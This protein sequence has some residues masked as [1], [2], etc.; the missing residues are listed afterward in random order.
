M[1]APIIH[2]VTDEKTPRLEY[3][4]DFMFNQVLQ[5]PFRLHLSQSAEIPSENVIYYG[6]E[7]PSQKI[8]IKAHPLLFDKSND[9]VKFKTVNY[10]L[11]T[12]P[13]AVDKGGILP[14]DPFA[15]AFYF[16]SQYEEQTNKITLDEHQRFCVAD[17]QIAPYIHYPMVDTICK[18]LKLRLMG[19]GILFGKHE[20]RYSFLPTFDIDI[21]YAHQAKSLK[22][23]FLGT[24]KLGAKF[25]YKEFSERV[26]VWVGLKGDPYD[27]FD[28]LLE[29]F[30]QHQV[31]ALFFALMA[32]SGKYNNN[33]SIFSPLYHNL[34]KKLNQKQNVFLHSS[35][36][37]MDE[38]TLLIEEKK[39]LEKILNTEIKANR[40]HFLRF[41][42]P[43]YWK[44]LIENNISND[45]SQGF[46]DTWGYRCGTSFSHKAYDVKNDKVLPLMVHPF[47]FMDTALIKMCKDDVVKVHEIMIDIILD[48]KKD[49]IPCT[50]VW[51][52]YA[53]PKGS[54]YLENFMDVLKY[55]CL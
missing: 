38:P 8:W 39:V 9:F 19:L 28:E 52:N 18:V 13:F 40:Q 35:F 10:Q 25:K 55:A 50:G 7:S 48:A 43:E 53:M 4:L 36:N 26:C 2:I 11:F 34:L 41:S 47:T 45:H 31:K 22:R 17:S 5:T 33:N 30:D 42:L 14:F 32:K 16:L 27:V 1:N 23:H 37:T 21:A 54:L 44:M 51:H 49:G 46:H 15:I 6:K 12:Y 29:V 3:V 24:A 20:N